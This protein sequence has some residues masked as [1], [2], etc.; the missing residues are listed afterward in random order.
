MADE[1]EATENSGGDTDQ[2][3]P[4][5]APTEDRSAPPSDGDGGSPLTTN[6]AVGGTPLANGVDEDSSEAPQDWPSNWREIMAGGDSK[7]LTRLARFNSPANVYKSWRSMNN[8]MSAGELLPARPNGED[9]DELNAWRAQAG[10]PSDPNG[11]L[12][13]FPDGLVVGEGDE[14]AINDFLQHA[15]ETDTPPKHVHDMLGWYYNHEENLQAQRFEQDSQF[16]QQTEDDLRTEY[17]PEFRG[18]LNGIHNTFDTYG[19]E[20]LADQIFTARMADGT[21][22]GDHPGFIRMMANVSTEINPHPTITPATG[23]SVGQTISSEKAQIEHAMSDRNSDYWKGP[24]A[25]SGE[26]VM[27]ERYRS[28]LEAEERIRGRGQGAR[29]TAGEQG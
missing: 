5:A 23:E 22:V 19:E 4:L 8:K 27:A 11:Y 9:A 26:T 20:G 24:K 10:I 21:L 16:R 6:G 15:H 13:H 18:N 14:G 3:V 7:E 25:E 28:L 12:E 2:G 17:G 1:F 29:A